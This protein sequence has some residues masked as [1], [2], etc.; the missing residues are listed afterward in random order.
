[1]GASSTGLGLK[2]GGGAYGGVGLTPGDAL[3]SEKPEEVAGAVDAWA[4]VAKE[5]FDAGGVD[6]VV[7]VL[8]I[9]L[10]EEGLGLAAG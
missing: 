10:P 3:A 9:V 1:M 8:G 2:A 5:D 6:E 7:Y 4:E